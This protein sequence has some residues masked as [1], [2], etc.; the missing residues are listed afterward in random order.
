MITTSSRGARLPLSKC[1]LLHG[2][3]V[4]LLCAMITAAPDLTAAAASQPPTPSSTPGLPNQ[5]LI[6]R[7]TKQVDQLSRQLRAVNAVVA[8][9]E[10][11]TTLIA[12]REGLVEHA[13]DLLG[14]AVQTT[15]RSLAAGL[16]DQALRIITEVNDLDQRIRASN[17][18]TLAGDWQLAGRWLANN[19]K[20]LSPQ[21]TRS[22]REALAVGQAFA[23]LGDP[24]VV[25]AESPLRSAVVA[26]T[27]PVARVAAQL[28][29][30]AYLRD[31]ARTADQ[32]L[33]SGLGQLVAQ[34]NGLAGRAPLG[35]TGAAKRLVRVPS[36]VAAAAANAG[37]QATALRQQLA[38][39]QH[40]LAVETNRNKPITEVD[41]INFPG[42][43]VED[44][45]TDTVASGQWTSRGADGLSV[46]PGAHSVPQQLI[47]DALGGL[48]GT[49]GHWTSTTTTVQ[50]VRL[51]NGALLE[52]TEESV[53]QLKQAQLVNNVNP[54][55]QSVPLPHAPGLDPQG[56]LNVSVS[57]GG[58]VT[59][60]GGVRAERA[61]EQVSVTVL[62]LRQP[63]D[64]SAAIPVTAWGPLTSTRPVSDSVLKPGGVSDSRTSGITVSHSEPLDVRAI[65][66]LNGWLAGRGTPLPPGFVDTYRGLTGGGLLQA[67]ISLTAQFRG[68]RTSGV[69]QILAPATPAELLREL[70]GDATAVAETSI[71]VDLS[72]GGHALVGRTLFNGQMDVSAIGQ[73]LG[74]LESGIEHLR[75]VIE[76]VTGGPG[77]GP[78]TRNQARPAM[79]P[80][81][82]PLPTVVSA[83]TAQS[84]TT[85]ATPGRLVNPERIANSA[86]G[87]YVVYALYRTGPDGT[88]GQFLKWGTWKLLP[89]WAD[90]AKSRITRYDAYRLPTQYSLNAT[91]LDAQGRVINGPVTAGIPLNLVVVAADLTKQESSGL[92]KML[93]D[94]R[95]GPLNLEKVPEPP[96]GTTERQIH[97]QGLL[98]MADWVNG[99]LQQYV[100]SQGIADR[101]DLGLIAD[102]HAM[103][104]GV[105][106]GRPL[107]TIS[108]RKNAINP[109]G[110]AQTIRAGHASYFTDDEVATIT[111][112]RLPATTTTIPAPATTTP[113]TATGTT[114]AEALV[115]L[116][117]Q[118]PVPGGQIVY[119]LYDRSGNFLRFGSTGDPAVSSDQP[120][121]MFVLANITGQAGTTAD[122]TS[123]TAEQNATD[124]ATAIERFLTAQWGGAHNASPE[125][126]L[127]HAA[128]SNGW[129][130]GPAQEA[131]LVA[132][133]QAMVVRIIP[134]ALAEQLAQLRAQ[135]REVL[136]PEQRAAIVRSVGDLESL[137][138]GVTGATS[139]QGGTATGGA[140]PGLGLVS[141][142]LG[143][144]ATP[145]GFPGA[146]PQLPQ[147]T[148]FPADPGLAATLA[149]PGQRPQVDLGVQQGLPANPGLGRELVTPP[150]RVPVELPRNH[151]ARVAT[152][153][154]TARVATGTTTARVATGTAGV[155]RPR[156]S[157]VPVTAPAQVTPAVVPGV[158]ALPGMVALPSAATKGLAS[159]SVD[160]LSV[161]QPTKDEVK[162]VLS[163]GGPTST[164]LPFFRSGAPTSAPAG[165]PEV[166]PDLPY[167]PASISG[168]VRCQMVASLVNAGCG[169]DNTD[170]T[171]GWHSCTSS[172]GSSAACFTRT[173]GDGTV[174]RCEGTTCTSD[175]GTI[176]TTCDTNQNT[177]VQTCGQTNDQTNQV[178]TC[179]YDPNSPAYCAQLNPNGTEVRCTTSNP[180]QSCTLTGNNSTTT[181]DRTGVSLQCSQTAGNTTTTCVVEHM[182]NICNSTGPGTTTRCD[183]MAQICTGTT[184]DLSKY[185]C[186]TTSNGA[187]DTCVITNDKGSFVCTGKNQSC[188]KNTGNVTIN[189]P[190]SVAHTVTTN[191]HANINPPSSA[192]PNGTLKANGS[193]DPTR[194]D[195]AHHQTQPTP[196][197][198]TNS[199]GS[200]NAAAPSPKPPVTSSTTP[201]QM[202][203]IQQNTNTRIQQAA[204]TQGVG[205]NGPGG[206]NW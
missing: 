42:A 197:S 139:E 130:L 31:R 110:P 190:T 24:P 148:G 63:T 82:R 164:L 33:A 119:A 2:L 89:K 152:G 81:N 162:A 154:A 128:N 32:H 199:G 100:T 158:T 140:A 101:T 150:A 27:G 155:A 10:R 147:P 115:R 47:V 108:P 174:T 65:Q 188:S 5:A 137:V 103:P 60:T 7:L 132:Q 189:K 25:G 11:V 74:A 182:H 99:A 180:T 66:L 23:D 53:A 143:N 39:T 184:P 40:A 9:N 177:N 135:L 185:T 48:A 116:H 97:D 124:Y 6:D 96:N 171:G 167:A 196:T 113:A 70:S 69:D 161:D 88:N 149:K 52:R 198:R 194:T 136:G 28:R 145:Q 206:G 131:D 153:T 72:A 166:A 56:L 45:R 93:R 44:T 12:L 75:T 172:P 71:V 36:A 80:V 195:Q 26:A 54:N 122:G 201:A 183:N 117:G 191:N 151:A 83:P 46:L 21:D 173:S 120:V 170:N 114:Q 20:G 179:I 98:S 111:G 204:N 192:Q 105:P 68:G 76:R 138:A 168:L 35:A 165:S 146:V 118:P 29:L 94:Y 43:V 51:P 121:D 62:V 157:H 41:P 16:T 19:S 49:T 1:R 95:G 84:A 176:R 57:Q 181:C 126:T 202:A 67:K 186:S 78:T 163:G 17:G 87:T 85:T 112:V 205:A 59:V 129:P 55:A 141:V 109:A 4:I 133:L 86:G 102:S 144:L 187:P 169:N 107:Q 15:D 134:E 37:H 104:P 142:D 13:A 203:T 90:P 73:V 92:E 106:N 178:S 8:A 200:A 22:V 3:L 156:G 18:K 175:N 159:S 91:Y 58:S 38:D 79:P 64:G 61:T 77:T 34:L 14:Q 160:Q 125:W 50:Q 193:N 123:W 127:I 30:G